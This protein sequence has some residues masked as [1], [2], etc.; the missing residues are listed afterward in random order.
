MS[1]G[2]E[3]LRTLSVR[4]IDCLTK[5]LSLFTNIVL[6]GGEVPIENLRRG[7]LSAEM[8]LFSG[9]PGKTMGVNA[10]RYTNSAYHK[11]LF[12]RAGVAQMYNPH[13]AESCWLCVLPE[14][15]GMGVWK[16]MIR[17]RQ[18]Y[19]GNRPSHAV[20]RADNRYVND[21]SRLGEYTQVGEEFYSDTS[22]DKLMLLVNNHDR[23][24]DKSKRL[25]YM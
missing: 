10:L 18:N 15:R 22:D 13:S 14:Y 7:I 25:Q 23:V 6:A 16:D 20:R 8:L 12:E 24:L 11:H 19:L 21:P 3:A 5:H 17:S 1:S 9:V 2:H 4:P